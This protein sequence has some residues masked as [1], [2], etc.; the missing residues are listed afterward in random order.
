MKWAAIYIR[1]CILQASLPMMLSLSTCYNGLMYSSIYSYTKLN[2]VD[3]VDSFLSVCYSQ[4]SN[5][6]QLLVFALNKA[7]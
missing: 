1:S 2:D 4:A 7:K 6:L 3:L 5:Q